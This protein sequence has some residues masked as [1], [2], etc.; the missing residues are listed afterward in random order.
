VLLILSDLHL[1]DETTASNVNPEAFELMASFVADTAVRRGAREI[2]VVLLGDILDLV[3]SDY[4]LTECPQVE[5]P[6][7]GT[8]DPRTAMNQHP[9]LESH[10]GRVLSLM[11][12]SGAAQKLG[13]ALRQLQQVAGE[14]NLPFEVVYVLGNHD[15]AL[16]NFPRLQDAVRKA[17]PGPF[18]ITHSIE[19]PEYS[20]LA[21]HGHEWDQHCHGWQFRSKVLVPDEN[22]DRFSPQA[23]E[24]MAIGEVVTAELMGGLIH[25]AREF[26]AG[27]DLLTELKDVNNLR[28][29]TAVF[30]WLD[31]LGTARGGS[32]QEILY[33]ALRQALDGVLESSF[34]REWDR[35][36][37]DLLLTGDLVDRLQQVKGMVLGGNFRAFRHRVDAIE[38]LLDVAG[39]FQKEKD[40]LMEGAKEEPVFEGPIRDDGIQYVVYGHTHRARNDYL[41][42]R[43]DGRVRMYVNTGTYLPLIARAED[44]SSFGRSLQMTMIYFFKADEDVANKRQET[45]SVDL[46]H[47]TRRKLY[48]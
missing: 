45:A 25:A 14:R 32:D 47:G 15:R 29:M 18:R 19:S 35:L 22:I 46:W 21:R 42:G 28:P 16:V 38:K 24:V 6:W 31:W 7:Y 13:E 3:R 39:L 11:L 8:L 12:S 30:G 9:A 20:V 40:H 37:T 44:G 36:T 41:A 17:F 43:P 5:R 34:A 1:T 48:A 4:W 2:R 10:Y 33:R 27:P 23:Y 26:G